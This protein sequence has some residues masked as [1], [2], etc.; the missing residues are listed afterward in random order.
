[1]LSLRVRGRVFTGEVKSNRNKKVKEVDKK[2]PEVVIRQGGDPVP[3]VAHEAAVVSGLKSEIGKV[4]K[5]DWVKIC[6]KG[7]ARPRWAY[8]IEVI[9]EPD[10]GEDVE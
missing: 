5:G 3:F 2:L 7:M 6:G 10:V 4:K 9:P 8:A 1:M